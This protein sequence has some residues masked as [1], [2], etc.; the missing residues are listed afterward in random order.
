MDEPTIAQKLRDNLAWM[1]QNGKSREEIQAEIDRAHKAMPALSATESTA[2]NELSPVMKAAQFGDRIA[3]AASFGVGPLVG[4]AIAAGI[5]PNQSFGDVR[6][7][8]SGR[9]ASLGKIGYV[10]DLIGGVATGGASLGALKAI[11]KVAALGW[12]GKAALAGADAM[13][14]GGVTGAAEGLNDASA[15]G[16]SNAAN[17]AKWGAGAGLLL[18]GAGGAIAGKVG[19]SVVNRGLLRDLTARGVNVKEAQ[20]IVKQLENATP[21]AINAALAKVDEIAALANAGTLAAFV[22]GFDIEGV[23][24]TIMEKIALARFD[25]LPALRAADADDKRPARTGEARLHR[26]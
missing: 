8:R 21:D 4:D 18:G 14:Q 19:A 6:A 12:K 20:A 24:E 13:L 17:M 25:S 1:R 3:G 23:G 5:D 11:P 26:A 7:A 22:A 10:A 2:A 9:N 16:L 15:A